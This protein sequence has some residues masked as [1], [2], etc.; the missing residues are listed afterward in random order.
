V[1]RILAPVLGMP[2]APAPP[3]PASATPDRLVLDA[4]R[5]FSGYAWKPEPDWA[6]DPPH[7]ATFPGRSEAL[8]HARVRPGAGYRLVL[9]VP[10]AMPESAR[11]ALTVSTFG[12]EAQH[13]GGEAGP[14]AF[15]IPEETVSRYGGFLE[16]LL[17]LRGLTAWPEAQTTDRPDAEGLRLVRLVLE[18]QGEAAPGVAAAEP[19]GR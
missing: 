5:P 13:L 2:D 18:R 4:T 15:H 11:Q 6:A 10:P 8:I 17:S 14:L 1:A 7:R 9:E 3:E 19:P 12:I 16:I